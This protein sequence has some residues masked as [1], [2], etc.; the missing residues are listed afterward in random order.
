MAGEGGL[1]LE[2]LDTGDLGDDLG[3]GQFPAAMEGQQCRGSRADS[4]T[5]PAGQGF[6]TLAEPNDLRELVAGKFGE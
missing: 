6:S 5:D 1:V 4:F 3:G 2:P